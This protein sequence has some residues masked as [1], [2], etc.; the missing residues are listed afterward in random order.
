MDNYSLSELKKTESN[1]ITDKHV[2]Y[3]SSFVILLCWKFVYTLS[4]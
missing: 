2:Q 1:N 4:L 3:S